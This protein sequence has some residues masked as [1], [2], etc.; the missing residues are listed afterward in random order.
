MESYFIFI[1]NFSTGKY[2]IFWLN[3]N[4][5]SHQELYQM[6][7]NKHPKQHFTAIGGGKILLKL[8]KK[9]LILFGTSSEFGQF[10]I[11]QIV[12]HAKSQFPNWTIYANTWSDK[13]SDAMSDWT[14]CRFK[15]QLFTGIY[16]KLAEYSAILQSGEELPRIFPTNQEFI[17]LTATENYQVGNFVNPNVIHEIK[18]IAHKRQRIQTK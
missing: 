9:E 18:R 16:D 6:Y 10:N 8:D 1:R 7:F 3:P 2:E 14:N 5:S 17:V 4:I 13:Y 15:Y 11:E 12:H